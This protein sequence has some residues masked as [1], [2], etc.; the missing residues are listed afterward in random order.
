M[1]VAEAVWVMTL[2]DLLTPANFCG[3][4]KA[5]GVGGLKAVEGGGAN[6]KAGEAGA[7]VG[8][9]ESKGTGNMGRKGCATPSG[10][11]EA[12]KSVGWI[13]GYPGREVRSQPCRSMG[14]R[15][16]AAGGTMRLSGRLTVGRAVV[17]RML[18]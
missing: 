18:S 1:R 4:R 7:A 15:V 10:G 11:I 9:G 8:L 3:C 12:P 16:V 5:G 6:G 13:K 17:G 14:S 2:G